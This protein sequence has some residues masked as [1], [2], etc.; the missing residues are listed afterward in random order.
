M[1]SWLLG[2][3]FLMF[4]LLRKRIPGGLHEVEAGLPGLPWLR[5]AR[6]NHLVEMSSL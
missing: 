2:D 5:S 3:D 6:R 1:I 4:S